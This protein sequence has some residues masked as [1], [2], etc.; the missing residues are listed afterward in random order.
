MPGRPPGDA[1]CGRRLCPVRSRSLAAGS[2]SLFADRAFAP[3]IH[4]ERI[5]GLLAHY[6]FADDETLAYF[7]YRLKEASQD[8]VFGLKYV[9]ERAL[10]EVERD[11]AVAALTFKTDV[12]W[13]QL[14][15][16]YGAYVTPGTP[17]PGAWQPG[18]G[19]AK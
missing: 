11:A 18:E 19:M 4:E 3:K 9:L 5:A 7:S 10:T 2:G 14:D 8:V 12:L 13:S 16:F 15:A 6:D 1:V 17:P